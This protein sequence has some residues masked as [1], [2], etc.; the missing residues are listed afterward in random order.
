MVRVVQDKVILGYQE[1]ENIQARTNDCKV[2]SFS[3]LSKRTECTR[4]AEKRTWKSK[5]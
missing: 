2:M 5:N 1:H 3:D 4:H